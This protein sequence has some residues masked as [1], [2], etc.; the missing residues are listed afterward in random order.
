MTNSL[1]ASS[2]RKGWSGWIGRTAI[3]VAL[4]TLCSCGKQPPSAAN[5]MP[6]RPDFDKLTD[7]FTKGV[8]ALSPVSA[9][10]AGYHEHNGASLDEMIDDYSAAGPGGI[11]AQRRFLQD[12][13]KRM[14]ATDV[15]TLDR[16]QQADLQILR[17]NIG[18]SLLE[19]D[20]I[21]NYRHNPTVYVELAGNALYTPFV[22][23]Y[24]PADA[25]FRHIIKRLEKIPALVDQA[26]ANLVDAPEIW[27]RVAREENDGNIGL[28]DQT[29]RKAAPDAL[30]ASY[31][32]AA[33]PAVAALKDLNGF[34]A[35][36]LSKKTSDWRLG[37]EK[38]A[39]KFG[40]VMATDVT[41]EQLLA[42]AEKD[43]QATRMEMATLAA[44]LTVKQALDEIATHHATPD[45]YMAEARKALEQA[46]AFVKEKQLVTLPPRSNLQ[47]IDTPEFMRGIYGVG[48][49]NSAPPLQPELGAFYWITPIP[50]TWPKAR[51]E[52][53]LREYNEYGVQQLTI[54]EAMPGHYVQQE[55]AND[56]QPTSRRVLRS[57]FA[58]TPYVEG[59]GMYT[60]QLM[61]EEGYLNNSKGLRLTWLKQKL[62]GIANTILDVRLQTMGMT[63]Q[64]A[65]DLMIND[66][67]QEREE[68]TAKLQRAQLSSCQL[69]TYYA[70]LRGWLHA[71]DQYKQSKGSA[72]SLRDF[73]DRAL[74]ESGVPLPEL[75]KLLR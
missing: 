34:L 7:D 40:Y 62:R 12:F 63:D 57:V 41:P 2:D 48:G 44:P 46:T 6:A 3:P 18:V 55:W 67:F 19:L 4:I 16:E 71:R 42:D 24:A 43:L 1:R 39:Q 52:S 69:P 11:E 10:Q 74:K 36:P 61:S 66:T 58:N 51:I 21:Q 47:V 33:A 32:A 68:A 54:H 73:H 53:K 64:Q 45:T 65:L 20:T 30:K 31:D 38:Y 49:F 59:W 60:Q 37:T 28:I 50:K 72:F 13:Q 9:T 29:L 75:E 70:G 25:R 15:A 22:L 8:L 27:N 26:K 17:N 56:V 35:G 14:A 23:E 5:T